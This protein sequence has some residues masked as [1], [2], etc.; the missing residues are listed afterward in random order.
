MLE[1]KR[2][3]S[4]V[5]S[6]LCKAVNW[7]FRV[8]GILIKLMFV[9]LVVAFGVFAGSVGSKFVEYKLGWQPRL[10]LTEIKV[11]TAVN[12]MD[13]NAPVIVVPPAPSNNN[14]PDL[15]EPGPSRIVSHV[16]KTEKI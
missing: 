9:V 1:M 12:I 5:W 16:T 8:I 15:S 7:L 6:L 11:E 4:I 3:L 2:K 13:V 14:I 10:N